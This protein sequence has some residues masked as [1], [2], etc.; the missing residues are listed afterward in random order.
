MTSASS[1]TVYV[2]I[3]YAGATTATV[4]YFEVNLYATATNSFSTAADY[5][6]TIQLPQYYSSTY[7]PFGNVYNSVTTYAS[8]TSSFTVGITPY[9]TTMALNNL[10]FDSSMTNTRSKITFDFGASSFRDVFYSTSSFHFDFGFIRNPSAN[11]YSRSN[12]RCMVYEGPNS[13][14]LTLSSAWKTLKLN[15]L[16]VVDLTPKA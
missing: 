16:S 7:V 15:S 3:H 1:S 11:Y 4:T 14:S 2:E 5:T 12:F 8:C 6:L 10:Q 9:G 13:T